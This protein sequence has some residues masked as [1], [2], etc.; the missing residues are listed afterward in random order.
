[1]TIHGIDLDSQAIRDFCNKWKIKE[2]SVFGSILRDD[3]RPDSDIDFLAVF[4]DCP[5]VHE[6][7]LFDD[8]HMRD[9]LS[10]IVGRD[11]DLVDK[12]VLESNSHRF[13]RAELLS[14]AE[15]VYALR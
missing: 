2:L 1:M 11:V 13:I 9:E 8:I 14:T 5:Q 15:Q 4:G 3:F 10:Q 12:S 6:Y 7:D